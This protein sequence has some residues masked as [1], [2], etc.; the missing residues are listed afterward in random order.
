MKTEV[1][2]RT[3]TQVANLTAEV[4]PRPAA[5]DDVAEQLAGMWKDLLS[6]D[7]VGLEDNYFDLGGDSSLAVHLFARIDK[8]FKIKLPIATLFEAPTIAEL[9]EIIRRE[10]PIFSWSCLVPIQPNG[11][12]PI[13]F[14]T[15]GAGGT[16][17]TYRDLSRE[18][19]PDQ[20]FYGLQAQGLDGNH[21]LLMRIE[22]MAA[23]YVKEIRQL[24]PHGPYFLSGYCMGG[25]IAFEI[26]Q[27]LQ[28]RG[29]KV[30]FLALFDTMNWRQIPLPSV[31]AK[32]YHMVERLVFHA[33]NFFLLDAQGKKKF[34]RE[35]VQ[36]L[37]N[38][39]PV[40]RGMLAAKLGLRSEI[41]GPEASVL[42]Q[43]WRNNDQAC[44]AY[45]AKPF[46]GAV[47]DFRPRAQYRMYRKA[48]AKWER[49]AEQGQHVVV[50]PVY[51]AGMLVEPFV[52]QLA[53]ELRKALDKA[54][55]HDNQQSKMESAN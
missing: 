24:Q 15:H 20:P 41:V 13:L 10:A 43:I 49:L 55:E 54:L 45:T 40:W 29:E 17:L 22:D 35:K 12:R 32:G 4:P 23:A 9:T 25:T 1:D 8:L 16:V 5:D 30:A 48:N 6:V 31:W 27:Q 18:L 38:R 39:V 33:A 44:I 36:V 26:A 19:G 47:I 50:L 34:F 37:R 2:C 51:P 42:G 53:I 46:P 52:K 7:S 14:C 11:S 3:R 28:A 21:P